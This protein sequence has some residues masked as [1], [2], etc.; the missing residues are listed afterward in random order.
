MID[1]REFQ[2][3][4]FSVVVVAKNHNPSLLNPDFLLI[5]HI[6]PDGYELA[7]PP[8]TT[9]PVAIVKYKQGISITVEME[10]L[11]VIETT[12]GE[13]PESPLA[14]DIASKY[15]HTLPHVRYTGVGINWSGF[16]RKKDPDLWICNRFL[17]KGP[18]RDDPHKLVS[19]VV[20]LTYDLGN[21]RC[22]L[23]LASG[24]IFEE[25]TQIPVVTVDV[26]Y[27]HDITAYPGDDDV[28]GVINCWK[29]RLHHFLLL[30]RDVLDLEA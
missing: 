23:S 25:E 5:R 2:L 27:H 20:R 14:T 24:Q 8:I 26:N 16:L 6:V 21:I 11:Q 19:S 7:E 13:F 17:S 9:P 12:A 3:R 29:D 4:T 28:V 22:N 15:V 1:K 10:K 18:W 30:I